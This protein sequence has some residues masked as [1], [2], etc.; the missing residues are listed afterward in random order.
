MGHPYYVASCVEITA[1]TDGETLDELV[2]NVREMIELY[3]EDTD[4]VTAFNLISNPRIVIT[5][6]LPENYAKTA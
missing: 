1:T 4:T 3:L 2:H 5:M 6:E